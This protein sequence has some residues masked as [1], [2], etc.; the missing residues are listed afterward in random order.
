MDD[1]GK[2]MARVRALQRWLLSQEINVGD[3]VVLALDIAALAIVQMAGSRGDAVM[4]AEAA[5][6]DILVDIPRL[7]DAR[8]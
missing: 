4:G 8:V 5:A 7:W 6:K 2:R 1:F 3:S